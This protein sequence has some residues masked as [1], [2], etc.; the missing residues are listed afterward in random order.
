MDPTGCPAG[1]RSTP[2]TVSGWTGA[3]VNSIGP[4][5]SPATTLMRVASDG[6]SVPGKYEAARRRTLA[7]DHCRF[8][9]H[10]ADARG[11]SRQDVL[12]GPQ[13]EHPEAAHVVAAN[14]EVRGEPHGRA[15]PIAG[16]YLLSLDRDERHRAAVFVDDAP[17]DCRGA[18]QGDDDPV[19]HL[20]GATVSGDGIVARRVGMIES[21]GNGQPS[22]PGST[23]SR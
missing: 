9:H 23:A 14:A 13:A 10:R 22:A 3:T 4:I 6:D 2:R 16:E 20:T 19:E 8:R 11:L 21:G 7:D 15:A 12:A 1:S 5:S 17:A 18:M